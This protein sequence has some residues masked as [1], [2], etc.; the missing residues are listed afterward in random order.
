MLPRESSSNFTFV[1]GSYKRTDVE[2]VARHREAR[3]HPFREAARER[4]QILRARR[5]ALLD[6]LGAAAQGG[7]DLFE[8]ALLLGGREVPALAGRAQIIR[9]LDGV[10]A[11]AADVA[12]AGEAHRRFPVL[13]VWFVT[14]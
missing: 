13:C 12:A 10:D 8:R 7:S 11:L 3:P 6:F 4:I 14:A 2:L 5:V 1:D 9:V